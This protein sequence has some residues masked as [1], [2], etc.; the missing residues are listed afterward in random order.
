MVDERIEKEDLPKPQFIQT[1]G[2]AMSLDEVYPEVLSILSGEDYHL[3]DDLLS[4]LHP[5]DLAGLLE[6]LPLELR[7]EVFTHLPQKLLGSIVSEVSPGVQESILAELSGA[8]LAEALGSLESDEAVDIVRQLDDDI[9]DEVLCSLSKEQQ[10]LY[11]YEEGTA[12]GL[13]KLEYVAVPA[14][15]T[16]VDVLKFMRDGNNIIPEVIDTI[17]V[18]NGHKK[19]VGTVGISRLVRTPLK[20]VMSDVMR[21]NPVS[22]PADMGQEDVAHI[23]EK[24]DIYSCPV[25]NEKGR[26][27]GVIAIDDILDVVVRE[28]EADIMRAAGLNEGEDLF[29]SAVQTTKKRFPWLFINLLTAILASFVISMFEGQ[30]EQLVVLAVLMPIVASMGGNAGTQTMTVAVRGLATKQLTLQ[31]AMA[32]LRKEMKVGG[33]NGLLLAMILGLLV[34]IVYGNIALGA[35]I[36]VAT[37]ANH[38]LAAFSGIVIPIYVEKLGKDPAL[39][40]GVIL[41]TV[42]DVGGF[43]IFLGL[44]SIFLL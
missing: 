32:L 4:P 29:S 11:A 16:V 8:S 23:F 22:V 20:T 18:L 19:L 7:E 2:Q 42:T 10:N 34:I 33:F 39:S 43:F 12:G 44:A 28:H 5:S 26:I 25:L 13:M 31:N 27:L 24:Y 17:Y 3:L 14:K 30:I 1:G 9:A 15:W 36:W 40:S 35:V 41:T 6:R 21:E 38:L 37:V